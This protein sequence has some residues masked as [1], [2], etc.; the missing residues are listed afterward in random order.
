MNNELNVKNLVS[1]F[2]LI[3]VKTEEIDNY[4]FQETDDKLNRD[5]LEKVYE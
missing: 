4:F 3:D 2:V 1:G 5:F